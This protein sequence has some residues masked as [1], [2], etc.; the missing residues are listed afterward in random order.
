MYLN[1]RCIS[2]V[3]QAEISVPASMP[4]LELEHGN[5]FSFSERKDKAFN[6]EAHEDHE[7]KNSKAIKLRVPS[8]SSW[9]ILAFFAYEA[10]FDS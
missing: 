9:L 6:H 2:V 10:W 7:G 1:I 8:C 3:L 4:V 5:Q